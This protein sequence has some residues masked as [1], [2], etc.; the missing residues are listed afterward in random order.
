MGLMSERL[1]VWAMIR[2]DQPYFF[3]RFMRFIMKSP[4]STPL[5]D[6]LQR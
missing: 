1:G 4:A 2:S 5:S 3:F 6:E